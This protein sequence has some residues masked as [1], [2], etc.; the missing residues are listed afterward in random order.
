MTSSPIVRVGD[1]AR[2]GPILPALPARWWCDLSD[3]SLRWDGGVFDLF[4]IAPGTRLDRRA[5]VEMYVDH[6]RAMLNRLR[7]AAIE[8]RGSFTFE[9]RIKRVDGEMRWM[10]V[11][12]DTLTSNG[13]VTHLYGTKRDISDEI[14]I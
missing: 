13:R 14:A 8:R 3:D 1:A 5:V 7:S 10:R 6:S 2:A 12:A 11:S 4:G 9:A